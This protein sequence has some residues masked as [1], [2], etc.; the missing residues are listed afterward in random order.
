MFISNH[1]AS[2]FKLITP[3]LTDH[4]TWQKYYYVSLIFVFPLFGL[5]DSK[6]LYSE[7]LRTFW[8][9]PNCDL[10]M[11]LTPLERMQHEASCRPAGEQQ[12]TEEGQETSTLIFILRYLSMSLSL[13]LTWYLVSVNLKEMNN[14]SLIVSMC[15]GF[16]SQ[17]VEKRVPPQCRVLPEFITVMSVMKTS[18]SP[19]LRSS[20]IKGSTC[21]LPTNWAQNL[22]D[23]HLITSLFCKRKTCVYRIKFFVFFL[24]NICVTVHLPFY[25]W[26]TLLKRH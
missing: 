5:Q 16:Q 4:H 7:C 6:D 2:H 9:C 12:Q 23:K 15:C 22:M 8:S 24:W 17:E 26:G 14:F 13:S 19:P 3:K 18:T 11:P 10:Y 20:N 21:L 1:L 25:T